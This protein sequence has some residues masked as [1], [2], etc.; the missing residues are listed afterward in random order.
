MRS[1]SQV[2][3]D[4]GVAQALILARN[5][6][7]AQPWHT[8]LTPAESIK[9]THLNR[10]QSLGYRRNY[11]S[12]QTNKVPRQC[13]PRQQGT[14]LYLGSLLSLILTADRLKHGPD[15]TSY[16]MVDCMRAS[17]VAPH[18]NLSYCGNISLL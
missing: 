18:F 10:E 8:N 14:R 16:I 12:V 13:H 5:D 6:G 2:R 17:S 3:A 4:S 7:V 1:S 15:L 9:W 11:I